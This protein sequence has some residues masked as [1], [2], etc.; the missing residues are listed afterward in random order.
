MFIS[1]AV[2]THHT[3]AILDDCRY[4]LISNAPDSAFNFIIQI[5]I[6]NALSLFPVIITFVLRVSLLIF[7][8]VCCP[9]CGTRNNII[10]RIRARNTFVVLTTAPRFLG[11]E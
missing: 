4:F 2:K 8:T 11:L 1:S 9:A 7:G 5:L 10:A 6:D 3:F